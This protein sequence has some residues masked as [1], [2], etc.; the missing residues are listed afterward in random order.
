MAEAHP[1]LVEHCPQGPPIP[2][3]LWAHSMWQN[4]FSGPRPSQQPLLQCWGSGGL[5]VPL[6]GSG[7]ARVFGVAVQRRESL[8][9]QQGPPGARWEETLQSKALSL[10]ASLSWWVRF[11]PP[12]SAPL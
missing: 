1:K 5:G 6:T 4:T 2:T 11:L 12:T 9:Q 7:L 8:E 10:R 3:V